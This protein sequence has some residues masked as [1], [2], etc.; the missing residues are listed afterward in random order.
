MQFWHSGPLMLIVSLIAA[1]NTEQ[2]PQ[3]LDANQAADGLVD[4]AQAQ[5]QSNKVSLVRF[6]QHHKWL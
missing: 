4:Q 3:R 1:I 2:T 6:H 5:Q